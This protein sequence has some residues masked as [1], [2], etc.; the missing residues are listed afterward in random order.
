MKADI[1]KVGVM[2]SDGTLS[3]FVFDGHGK[4]TGLSFDQETGETLWAGYS[5]EELKTIAET[6]AKANP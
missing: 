1:T 5:Y 2:L 4:G 6:T 3:G